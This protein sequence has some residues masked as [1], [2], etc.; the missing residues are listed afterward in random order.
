MKT[1][2]A[3]LSFFLFFLL[4]APFTST[5]AQSFADD[6]DAKEARLRNIYED[7]LEAIGDK[8]DR[9]PSLKVNKHP[10]RIASLLKDDSGSVIYIDA[11]AIDICSQ[12][13]DDPTLQD[14]LLAFLIGHELSHFYNGD[15]NENFIRC[16]TDETRDLI[17][18]KEE[19]A[20]EFAAYATYQTGYDA[21]RYIAP[22]VEELYKRY[23]PLDLPCS[24]SAKIRGQLAES[25]IKRSEKLIAL[26]KTAHYLFVA[27]HYGQAL[28]I[29]EYIRSMIRFKEIYNN[30]G[31]LHLYGFANAATDTF[32]YCYPMPIALEFPSQRDGKERSYFSLQK[33]I[34]YLKE[35][36]KYEK[37]NF[38]LLTNLCTAYLQSEQPIAAKKIIDDLQGNKEKSAVESSTLKILT[39][40]WEDQQLDGKKA[41]RSA[42][43]LL[44]ETT[45]KTGI[46]YIYKQM[47]QCNL[48]YL[49]DRKLKNRPCIA[50]DLK[51][52][53]IDVFDGPL[54]KGPTIVPL[55][56]DREIRLEFQEFSRGQRIKGQIGS[57]SILVGWSSSMP[58]KDLDNLGMGSRFKQI[59]AILHRNGF[60]L[61][62]FPYQGG[63]F[64][65][66]DAIGL[67]FK[68]NQDDV[69]I[70]WAYIEAK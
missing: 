24:L 16:V 66:V 13:F 26:N 32:T 33:A 8:S 47:A 39:A 60:D 51:T 48:G 29:Y 55:L 56:E 2:T 12:L 7:L 57:R 25:G 67:I 6:K 14:G 22:F 11:L 41:P 63:S 53:S 70:E 35:G 30:L 19:D 21:L 68:L 49:K 34:Q 38:T 28:P 59:E 37:K 31:A 18:K 54:G 61:R 44:E 23:R 4:S 65:V 46:P 64:V 43:K 17:K 36:L 20:D 40:I 42:L 5:K 69:V 52:E 10:F 1:L 9:I 27:G 3:F 50:K 58:I 45:L 15:L 62:L